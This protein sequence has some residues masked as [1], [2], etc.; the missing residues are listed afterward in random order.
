MTELYLEFRSRLTSHDRIWDESGD[1]RKV[2]S[3]V[4][5]QL[6]G[7]PKKPTGTSL[8]H[9]IWLSR[10]IR[11]WSVGYWAKKGDVVI[12]IREL[13]RYRAASW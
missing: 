11:L 12:R 5:S 13:L 1:D 2:K 8:P 6:M 9:K 7:Q 10:M 3:K 4:N